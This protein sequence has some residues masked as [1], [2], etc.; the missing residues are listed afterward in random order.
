MECMVADMREEEREMKEGLS[1]SVL[2]KNKR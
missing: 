1:W 2:G